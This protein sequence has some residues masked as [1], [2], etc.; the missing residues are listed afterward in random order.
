MMFVF[1]LFIQNNKKHI[2][3]QSTIQTPEQKHGQKTRDEK[4][5]KW[6][7][8]VRL[9]DEKLE[10]KKEQDKK[11]KERMKTRQTGDKN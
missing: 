2:E 3:T 4:W 10:T 11:W 6:G 8:T 9:Q 1:V 7:K 5:E